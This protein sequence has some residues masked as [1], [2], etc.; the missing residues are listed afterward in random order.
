MH[1][2]G[3]RREHPL[4]PPPLSSSATVAGVARQVDVE[5]S[6]QLAPITDPLRLRD[7]SFFSV[8]FSARIA[9][10]SVPAG[11]RGGGENT[12]NTLGLG[13]GIGIE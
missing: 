5:I 4:T 7:Q 3:E 13:A 2:G 11:G 12:C 10:A 9:N 6:D 1:A 8:L